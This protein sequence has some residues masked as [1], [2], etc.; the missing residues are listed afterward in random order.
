M[1]ML[2]RVRHPLSLGL[3]PIWKQNS[4]L[5]SIQLIPLQRGRVVLQNVLGIDSKSGY[6]KNENESDFFSS[7]RFQDGIW[8]AVL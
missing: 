3:K 1:N 8:N 5:L 7:R 2:K 4:E 6:K